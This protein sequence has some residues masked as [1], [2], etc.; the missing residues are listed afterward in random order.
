MQLAEPD[1]S[2]MVKWM[3]ERIEYYKRFEPTGPLRNQGIS[4][5]ADGDLSSIVKLTGAASAAFWTALLLE[6]SFTSIRNVNAMF[7]H[8]EEDME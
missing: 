8:Q 7:L 4:L 5:P 3:K 1:H 2:L 6:D